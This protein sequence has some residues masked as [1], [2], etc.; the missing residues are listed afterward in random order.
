[1]K[2]PTPR[3]PAGAA[4]PEPFPAAAL[5]GSLPDRFR[6]QVSRHAARLAVKAGAE[7]LDYAVLDRRSDA[8]ARAVRERAGEAAEPVGVLLGQCAALPV[9]LLGVLKSGQI[10]APLDPSLPRAR[11]EFMLRDLEAPLLLTSAEHR[12]LAQELA[13]EGCGV[14][15][16]EDLAPG[17]AAPE[18]PELGPDSL[19]AIIYT[20]G[21]TGDP[22][23]VL[24]RHDNFLHNVQHL[25]NDQRLG[26]ADRLALLIFPGF[27]SSVTIMLNALLNGG[28]VFPFDIRREGPGRLASWLD[29]EQITYYHS[30]VTLF[31]QVMSGLPP[32]RQVSS[33]RLVRIA[34]EGASSSDAALFRRHF[35]PGAMLVHSMGS[36]E[37][38]SFCIYMLDHATAVPPGPLPAGYAVEGREVL[39][40]GESGQELPRGAEGEIAVRSRYLSPGYWRRPD[41][42]AEKFFTDPRDPRLRVYRTGDLGRLEPEGCLVHLGRRDFQVKIRG[43][44]V[45]IGE[46]EAAL[47]QLD[48]VRDAAVILR[49]DHPGEPRL[50]AYL[51]PAGAAPPGVSAL[52]RGLADSLPAAMI[53]SV[54]VPL[55]ALPLTPSLKLDRRALAALPA[56]AGRP[57]LDIPWAAPRTPLEERVAESW[58]AVLG[59]EEVGIH[60][61]FAELGGT[62]LAATRILSRLRDALALEPPLPDFMAAGTVAEQ[63][64]LLLRLMAE[65]TNEDELDSMVAEVE[66]LGSCG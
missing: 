33:V 15:L 65:R 22:K 14:Q 27:I 10:Y 11:L 66:R 19:A 59:V 42:T 64:A 50:I 25:T 41:L 8:V 61:P 34:S 17:D 37:A 5:C 55:S 6:E 49:E 28:A 60:D 62:S 46:V 63:A 29:E 4:P 12:A 47:R 24:Y 31:R 13:P 53:P 57:D 52:R 44:R 30:S 3:L 58:T 23:G 36:T 21:S 40:L 38:Q 43:H 26:P 54:F 16:L 9:A 1:M 51:V 56:P 35:A 18:L 39:I 7:A 45:E 20:S 32:D 48:G 2:Y